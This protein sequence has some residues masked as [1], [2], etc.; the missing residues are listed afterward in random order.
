MSLDSFK[1]SGI[2]LILG[3]RTWATGVAHGLF[4]GS[5]YVSGLLI[6]RVV[7]FFIVRLS[8]VVSVLVYIIKL[9]LLIRSYIL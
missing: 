3:L 6:V 2:F 9:L 8:A 7:S 1:N 5:T 4:D